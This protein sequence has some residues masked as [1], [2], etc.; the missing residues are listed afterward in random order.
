V[1]TSIS[2][3]LSTVDLFSFLAD[4]FTFT[5]SKHDPLLQSNLRRLE[6]GIGTPSL[7]AETSVS[8]A[9][10]LP[11]ASHSSP[12]SVFSALG[13][14]S[15]P[16]FLDFVVQKVQTLPQIQPLVTEYR[17]TDIPLSWGRSL[18]EEVDKTFRYR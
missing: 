9:S 3:T 8:A 18:F 6:S 4:I 17:F 11:S 16:K 10:T 2:K 5:M 7:K 15:E 1:T 13:F 14:E 12:Q